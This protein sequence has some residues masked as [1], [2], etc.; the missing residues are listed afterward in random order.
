MSHASSNPEMSSLQ[1]ILQDAQAHQVTNLHVR[2]GRKPYWRIAGEL[3]SSGYPETTESLFWQWA[4]GLFSAETL[5]KFQ[6][7]GVVGL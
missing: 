2:I 4:G 5:A 3:Q 1:Q 6:G 7:G